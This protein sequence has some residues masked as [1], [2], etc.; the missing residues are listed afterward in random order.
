MIK[1]ILIDHG[2]GGLIG[3]KYVTPGK[4][5]TIDD[6]TIFEGLLNRAQAHLLNYQLSLNGIESEIIAPE[7][8]DATLKTRV[9][10][11]NNIVRKN[12]EEFLLVMIHSNAHENP[13]AK[14]WEIFTSYGPTASDDYA[15]YF[16]K[17]FVN[18]FPDRKL[19]P[20][21]SRVAGMKESGFSLLVN[22]KCPA[23]YCE[24]LFMT[25]PEEFS[26]LA[27]PIEVTHLVDYKLRAIAELV[28]RPKLVEIREMA[29]KDRV[30]KYT[31][32]SK[33]LIEDSE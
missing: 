20:G 25:N 32:V 5:G 29:S 3:G 22:T 13:E 8:E 33:M 27:D 31:S 23:V 12:P 15:L 4:R 28:G 11:V 18:T 10:R 14:G 17:H 24:D 9:M 1:R 16:H 30:G 26:I 6:R 2:H 19:R 7:N 21:I